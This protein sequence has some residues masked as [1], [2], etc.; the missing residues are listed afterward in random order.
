MYSRPGSS[1]A[2]DTQPHASD[3]KVLAGE[4]LHQGLISRTQQTV[5]GVDTPGVRAYQDAGLVLEYINY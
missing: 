2:P 5:D 4:A 3:I 1:R